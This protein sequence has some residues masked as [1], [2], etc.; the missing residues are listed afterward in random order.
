MF[1]L[2]IIII[3][4]IYLIGFFNGE[5]IIGKEITDKF[6]RKHFYHNSLYT[7]NRYHYLLKIRKIKLTHA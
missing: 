7:L 5:N 4:H 2:I 1:F 3:L 6:S